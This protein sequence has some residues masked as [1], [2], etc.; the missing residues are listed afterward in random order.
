MAFLGYTTD[1]D[2]DGISPDIG[3]S[4]ATSG[5]AG[6]VYYDIEKIRRDIRRVSAK[7][8]IICISLHWGYELFKYPS[9]KQIELAHQIIDAGANVIIGHHPHI[10]QGIEK[11]KQGV[12]FYSL[13]NF[14]FWNYYNLPDFPDECN[15]FILG[16]CEINDF[17]IKRVDVLPGFM[18]I[19]YQLKMLDGRDKEEYLSK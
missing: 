12:I 13:G 11:Y 17:G 7:A 14:F 8:D 9:P 16:V 5:S 6:C 15:E 3:A 2:K 1:T 18:D 10:V 19:D 4:I